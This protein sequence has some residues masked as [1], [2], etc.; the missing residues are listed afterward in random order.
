[1][2]KTMIL[3]IATILLFGCVK[4]KLK[5]KCTCVTYR[6]HWD[7]YSDTTRITSSFTSDKCSCYRNDTIAINIGDIITI[8]K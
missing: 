4:H 2:K 3:I 1:M 5:Y 6:L 7:G 8:C